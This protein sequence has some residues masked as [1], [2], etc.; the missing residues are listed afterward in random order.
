MHAEP[1][2]FE[3]VLRSQTR[4]LGLSLL[5]KA[6]KGQLMPIA[7]QIER[8]LD[9]PFSWSA[10]PND[11]RV[12][13]RLVS[14]LKAEVQED[15]PEP[16]EVYIGL[17]SGFRSCDSK[18][19]GV[20]DGD[21]E[22]TRLFIARDAK[23]FAGTI[24]HTFM[25][26]Q[27]CSRG[28]CFETEQA[29]ARSCGEVDDTVLLPARIAQDLEM[30]SPEESLI[31]LQ[32][33]AIS[34]T[35]NELYGTIREFI[36]HELIDVTSSLQLRKASAMAYLTGEVSA[37][38]LISQR[39]QWYR[40]LKISQLPRGETAVT[41]FKAIDRTIEVALKYNLRDQL[42]AFFRLLEQ[43]ITTDPIDVRADILALSVFC[44]FR[45]HACDEIYLEITDRNPYMNDQP[46]QA[47][48]FAELFALGSHC[49]SYFDLTAKAIGRVL[50]AKYRA[51]YR[52]YP[53]QID[54]QATKTQAT[55]YGS[56]NPDE[57]AE[58]ITEPHKG[59]W[60]KLRNTSYIGVYSFPA[61]IDIL[62]LTTTG[63]GLYLSAYM[64]DVP[65]RVATFA[66]LISLVISG[67]VS[68]WICCG[69]SYYLWAR[70]YSTMNAFMLTRLIGGIVLA[71]IVGLL[72]VIGFGVGY[73][74]KNGALT[75]LLAAGLFF[76]YIMVL[77]FYLYM[78]AM[79]SNLQFPGSPLPSVT[80]LKLQS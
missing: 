60:F 74:L 21:D 57:D 9:D 49:E 22:T 28:K 64:G 36:E 59:I 71:S 54:S 48:I 10:N 11:H 69:G 42:E 55:M 44:A 24:L 33:L 79:L 72:S 52:L 12:V 25:S 75:G 18:L 8:L 19:W 45:K 70:V 31:L 38:D 80:P 73:G 7:K 47:A 68:A 16:I 78:L 61:L 5:Q 26:S 23:D 29:L 50:Y 66:L 65:Q 6:E 56:A 53:P 51:F 20:Y 41:L 63:R 1:H 32:N 40:Q 76:L 13:R 2:D 4:L 62:L 15:M 43:V 46:D 39:F 35:T 17:D 3:T 30:L 34:G 77:T 67:A 27:N 37:E 14:G 58:G